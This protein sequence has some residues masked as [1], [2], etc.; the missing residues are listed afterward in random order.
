MTPVAVK[1]IWFI[2][3]SEVLL[4]NF[5]IFEKIQDAAISE[6]VQLKRKYTS[7]HTTK[8]TNAISCNFDNKKN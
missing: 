7:Y 8:S 6:I 5:R 4:I 2:R 3:T 1:T